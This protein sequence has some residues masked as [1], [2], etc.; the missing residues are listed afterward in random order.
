[1]EG[2]LHRLSCVGSERL[3]RSG[4]QGDVVRLSHSCCPGK[5]DIHAPEFEQHEKPLKL[6]KGTMIGWRCKGC[7]TVV[8]VFEEA[9]TVYKNPN[10]SIDHPGSSCNV[11]CGEY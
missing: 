1:V 9:P 11:A 10:C 4:R 2:I 3:I 5:R 6:T 8:Y 7:Q